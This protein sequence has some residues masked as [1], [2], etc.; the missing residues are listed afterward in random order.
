M[1]TPY[2][3]NEILREFGKGVGL[4]EFGVNGNDAA[5]LRFDSG[6]SIRFEYALETL[7]I[8]AE[9]PAKPEIQNLKRLL[10]YALPDRAPSFRLRCAFVA[11]TNCAMLAAR[12]NE[13][14][15]TLP[16]LTSVFTELF[17]LAEDFRNRLA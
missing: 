13:R 1:M 5:V 11:D 9:V 6:I 7:V 3:L 10:S 12:I 14:E 15:V 16:L 4:K 17:H 8:A 2:W